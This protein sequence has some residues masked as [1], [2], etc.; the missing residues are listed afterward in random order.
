MATKK[1]WEDLT[2]LQ[3]EGIEL[4]NMGQIGLPIAALVD[5]YRRR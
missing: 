4:S 1:R 5:I 3:K 2:T